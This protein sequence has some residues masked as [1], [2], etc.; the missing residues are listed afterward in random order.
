MRNAI[1]QDNTL[2]VT[3]NFL[4]TLD[5]EDLDDM[6]VDMA[7]RKAMPLLNATED[8]DE[9]ERVISNI[10]YDAS[11]INNSGKTAQVDY[12]VSNGFRAKCYAS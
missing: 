2:K 12:L 3:L 4:R 9:Q 5:I 7:Y 10:E 11:E 6:V 8:L 1:T